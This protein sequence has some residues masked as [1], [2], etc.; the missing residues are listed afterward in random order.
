MRLAEALAIL[1][2]PAPSD[3]DCFKAALVCGF[4]PL[5]LKTFLGARL[6]TALPRHQVEIDTGLYGDFL[7]NLDRLIRNPTDCIVVAMEWSDVDP[8]LGMR[9]L[10]GWR[11]SDFSEIVDHARA[12]IAR[13]QELMEGAP[14]HT[15]LVIQLPTLPLPP[16]EPQFP[17][18]RASRF[19]L[20]LQEIL[21]GFALWALVSPA[22]KIANSSHLDR[23][24]PPA[25]RFDVQSELASGFP[26]TLPHASAVSEIL[27]D[28]IHNPA[29]K[30]GLITD[31]DDTLWKGIL[32]EVGPAGVSWDLDH[33]SHMHAV[34][35]GLLR[36][37]AE[38]GVLIA[39]ASKNEAAL[40]QKVFRREDLLLSKDHIFPCEVH[41]APKSGSVGRILEAWNI[42]A[43]SVV[44]VDDSPTEL[45][46][47]KS[48]HPAVECML[49]PKAPQEIYS[50]V[51][52]LRNLFAKA[53]VTEEDRLRLD[54][55]RNRHA[56]QES[57]LL[58]GNPDAFLEQAE[59]VLTFG[60]DKVSADP[61]VLDL[62]NKTNQFNLNGRRY[63]ETGLHGLLQDPCV[64]LMKAGYTDKFGP[65]GKIAI[66]IGR[67]AGR[68][69]RVDS[70]VM[71]CR[72][73]SRRIEHIFLD[74][75]F[76]KFDIDEIEFDYLP[77][78]RNKPLQEFF[79]GLLG[80][81]LETPLRLSRDQ[82][83]QKCP[84]LFHRVEEEV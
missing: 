3:G 69:I 16:I 58:A 38:T 79:A 44:M 39:V 70:W 68:H 21:N 67:V 28:L 4:M 62:L 2:Q 65:L 26:Y 19:Q 7:G 23:I 46:E 71:S 8:R 30:K 51:G 76:G 29:P 24:S 6:R 13:M 17:N 1:N 11:Q 49:F 15:P 83:R 75:L 52:S 60:F 36:S 59:S 27:A 35:Q 57:R 10:S 72:A 53:T 40:V 43:D 31:L 82:F 32:G 84:A 25:G 48:V 33:R 9:S 20:Q 41:W 74:R 34:Y 81:P 55:I 12:K 18:W 45:A 5:H 50:L 14:A 54:S 56:A 73:F 64:F 61:R 66:L 22:V 78:E 80:T 47:V 63:T 37:M 42:G 77:T